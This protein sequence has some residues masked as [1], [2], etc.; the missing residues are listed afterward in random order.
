[1]FVLLTIAGFH[2]L[3]FDFMVPRTASFAI[4]QK[5]K[6]VPLRE[7]RATV[8]GYF[9]VPSQGASSAKSDTWVFGAMDKQFRLTVHYVYD[10]IAAS[11]S[12]HYRYSKWFSSRDYLLDTATIR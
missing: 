7:S 3:I 5:W 1:M 12:V 4:P 11:Y 9:G 2:Y 8:Q 10:S 6:R